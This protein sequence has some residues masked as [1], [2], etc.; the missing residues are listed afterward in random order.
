MGRKAI[1]RIA[2]GIAQD[3]FD[4]MSWL[5]LPAA[6]LWGIMGR[7]RTARCEAQRQP[8]VPP[9]QA[10]AAFSIPQFG[11]SEFIRTVEIHASLFG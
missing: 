7:K 4:A 11:P 8:F 3:G 6:P 5:A 2:Y 1:E 10:K 9:D